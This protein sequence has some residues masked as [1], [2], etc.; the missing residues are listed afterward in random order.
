MT[1]YRWHDH[2]AKRRSPVLGGLK[3]LINLFDASEIEHPSQLSRDLFAFV[4]A[5]AE[6]SSTEEDW[7]E[8]SLKHER[9]N[10]LFVSSTQWPTSFKTEHPNI[11]YI[12]QPIHNIA[13]H[14]I[15]NPDKVSHF[16]NSCNQGKPDWSI[17][18]LLSPY[19]QSL[20]AA[21]LLLIA[22]KEGLII[23]DLD[24]TSLWPEAGKEFSFLCNEKGLK[25]NVDI[26]PAEGWAHPSGDNVNNAVNA[27]RRLF[28]SV[29][30][31]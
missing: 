28:E 21:Y 20:V 29:S 9:C 26:I 8:Q 17:L 12:S 15:N 14:L 18:N 23:N 16:K 2:D 5:G 6:S 11:N 4:H 1:K 19:P 10:I 24:Q 3:E 25:G 7:K 31:G 27:I 22:E 13:N 30:G